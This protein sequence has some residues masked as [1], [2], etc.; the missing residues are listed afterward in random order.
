[1]SHVLHNGTDEQRA[2]DEDDELDFVPRHLVA[3]ERG[4]TS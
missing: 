4:F 1:M 3:V 2:Q